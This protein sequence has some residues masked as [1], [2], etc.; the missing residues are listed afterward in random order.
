MG[1]KNTCY[2]I[3]L[4]NKSEFIVK[5][6]HFRSLYVGSSPLKL[7]SHMLKLIASTYKV[8][9]FS[10]LTIP[11]C[12]PSRGVTGESIIVLVL[13]FYWPAHPD[14]PQGIRVASVI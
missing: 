3:Y 14:D 6:I 10:H 7:C 1:I 8:K 11:Y 2:E 12:L 9:L 4:E 5:E 13:Y